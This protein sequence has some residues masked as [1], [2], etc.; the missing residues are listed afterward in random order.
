MYTDFFHLKL[1]PF[2][3][4]PDPRYLFMTHGHR[5]ALA[6]LLYGVNSGGGLVLLTGEIGAGKTTVCRYFL[7]QVPARCNVAYIFNPKLTVVELLQSICD[8][9]G[10]GIRHM[11]RAASVKDYVDALTRYLI[12]SHADGQNNVLIIDEAQNLSAE[13]L[14]QLRLLTNL[15]TN[16]RKLLQIIMIGQPEL[17]AMLD[18]PELQQLSQRVI[19]R[20]HLKALSEQ[21]T[22][23]YIQHRLAVAGLTG[24][25]P[26]G[27]TSMKQ[28]HQLSLGVPR[29]INL[30][31]DR[32]LLG[33]YS[34]DK[35][36]LSRAMIAKAAAEVFGTADAARNGR[37]GAAFGAGFKRS[38][39]LAL[40]AAALAI[41]GVVWAL[42]TIRGE[43]D[44]R[45]P[46]AADTTVKASPAA[47][48]KTAAEVKPPPARQAI[49]I[50]S[51]TDGSS[52]LGLE[53]KDA[54]YQQLAKLWG[55]SVP[56]DDPCVTARELNLHC[57]R[58]SRGFAELR[59]LDRPALLTLRDAE[60][61]NYYVLLTGLSDSAATLQVGNVT[62]TVSL[63]VLARY[64][65]G[66]FTTLWRA[67]WLYRGYL[68]AGD[69]GP[70][71]DW[72]AAQLARLNG[73]KPPGEH[74]MLDDNMVARIREFQTAQGL[75]PDGMVGPLTFM[76]LNRAS[77]VDEPRLKTSLTAA[78]A[79]D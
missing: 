72:I 52:S 32:A 24:A 10:A 44:S 62:Q 70:E 34:K 28:I 50:L 47:I 4:A 36:K 27:R 37:T 58:S 55:V 57:Y 8:E 64:F 53:G 48:Q 38:G 66:D 54:A 21:E 79:T 18:R 40:A 13:V 61:R 45:K 41:G 1:A 46:V 22:A 60:A 20:Y 76:H 39:P 75:K 5:E 63:L 65:D 31:C 23:S 15:E 29:R 26:F 2:S 56:D 42:N 51:E 25:S 7:D 73:E 19:A 17:R 68:E 30:L 33:A 11:P 43:T 3:I 14:E 35:R 71:V 78:K 74:Q 9:F 16:E 69:K 49:K 67:P 6:H 77:G 12:A 59:Q